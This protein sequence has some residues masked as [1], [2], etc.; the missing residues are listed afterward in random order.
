MENTKDEAIVET[1]I[2]KVRI[3][4]PGHVYITVKA[5]SPDQAMDAAKKIW[6]TEE[7]HLHFEL[8]VVAGVTAK[9]V[10]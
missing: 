2:Y 1:R 7:G 3:D 10:L 5:N 6:E 9:V 8:N 4:F